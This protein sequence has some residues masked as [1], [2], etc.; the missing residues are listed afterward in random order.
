MENE[1]LDRAI[2]LRAKI[3]EAKRFEDC[4][5]YCS[6]VGYQ[7]ENGASGR[8]NVSSELMA[9]IKTLVQD[10]CRKKLDALA[11]EFSEL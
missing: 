5:N 11:K 7:R 10:D 8:I 9:V 2:A 4:S 1:K 6:H 3:A